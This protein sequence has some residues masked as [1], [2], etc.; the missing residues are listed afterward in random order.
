M[1]D[2]ENPPCDAAGRSSDCRAADEA[3]LGR[4]T[5]STAN[6]HI[7]EGY[8]GAEPCSERFQNGLLCRETASQPFDPIRVAGERVKLLLGETPRQEGITRIVDP[9]TQL[10]DEN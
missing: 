2:A 4:R 6:D 3:Y 7:A 1:A 10:V 8:S 5:G 9:A